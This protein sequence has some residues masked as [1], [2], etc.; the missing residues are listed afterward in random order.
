MIALASASATRVR[1][2]LSS[3]ALIRVPCVFSRFPLLDFAGVA[4]NAVTGNDRTDFGIAAAFGVVLFAKSKLKI[5]I[6]GP[7]RVVSNAVHSFR[8]NMIELKR[9][10]EQAQRSVFIQRMGSRSLRSDC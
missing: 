5:S 4:I 10:N 7:F 2:L 3:R 1:A 8:I 9:A 6:G